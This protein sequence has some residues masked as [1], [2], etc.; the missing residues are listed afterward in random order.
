MEHVK[1]NLKSFVYTTYLHRSKVTRYWRVSS[2]RFPS[3]SWTS[4]QPPSSTPTLQPP[5]SQ[6]SSQCYQSSLCIAVT[7]ERCKTCIFY[8]L[9]YFSFFFFFILGY[10]METILCQDTKPISSSFM[11]ALYF[12]MLVCCYLVN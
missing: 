5:S 3:C 6:E 9:W 8:S 10:I 12:T 2:K 7:S 11:V 1:G 4:T